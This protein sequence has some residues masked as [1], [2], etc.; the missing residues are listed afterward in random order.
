MSIGRLLKWEEKA[1]MDVE[2]EGADFPQETAS[3][4]VCHKRP[5]SKLNIRQ[6]YATRRHSHVGHGVDEETD[7]AMDDKAG[8]DV[9]DDG[10]EGIPEE[11]AHSDAVYIARGLAPTESLVEGAVRGFCA[12]SVGCGGD[13]DDAVDL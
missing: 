5:L 1:P 2:K 7:N 4:I 8:V 9:V 12:D 13:D 6:G 10:V 11:I 3:G